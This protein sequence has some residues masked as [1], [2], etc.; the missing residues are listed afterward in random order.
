[1]SYTFCHNCGRPVYFIQFWGKNGSA[2]LD[3]LGAPWTEHACMVN[4]H[5]SRDQ[6]RAAVHSSRPA[7][8]SRS[9]SVAPDP[10]HTRPTTTVNAR[11]TCEAAPAA[12]R[13]VRPQR[14]RRKQRPIDPAAMVLAALNLHERMQAALDPKA[15][16]VLWHAQILAVAH[17]ITC[18]ARTFRRR[19]PFSAELPNWSVQGLRGDLQ[20]AAILLDALGLTRS[21]QARPGREPN[22]SALTPDA[23]PAAA[24]TFARLWTNREQVIGTVP[25]QRA[26]ARGANGSR[27][28]AHVD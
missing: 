25:Q 21:P 6:R 11:R 28:S 12:R 22:W 2:Y 5:L 18:R 16:L 8:A 24:D 13:E 3:R 27:R 7:A 4:C 15:E 14:S 26:R 10:P 20:K 23:M 9:R 19:P 1:M 17:G